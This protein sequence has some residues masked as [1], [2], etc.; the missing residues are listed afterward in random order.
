MKNIAEKNNI[1]IHIHLS[2]TNVEFDYI[3]KNFGL[4]PIKH[5]QEIGLLGSNLIAA[6]CNVVEEGDLDLLDE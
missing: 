5:A 2:Q 3:K 1:P 4:S 6:H